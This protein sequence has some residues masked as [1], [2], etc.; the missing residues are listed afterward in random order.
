[1]PDGKQETVHAY[2]I[3]LS[4]QFGTWESLQAYDIALSSLFGPIQPAIYAYDTP[5]YGTW[6]APLCMI[7]VPGTPIFTL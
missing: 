7:L 6:Y 3:P 1:M 2:D 4:R 5:V